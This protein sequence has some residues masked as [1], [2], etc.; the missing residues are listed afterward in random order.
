MKWLRDNPVIG[1]LGLLGTIVVTVWTMS[2]EY[3]LLAKRSDVEV[4]EEVL[5][6]GLLELARCVDNPQYVL[7]IDPEQPVASCETRV[8]R[9]LDKH[10]DQ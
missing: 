7:Q 2:S 1:L 4:V 5:K 10:K 9:T 3:G 8:Y 6:S